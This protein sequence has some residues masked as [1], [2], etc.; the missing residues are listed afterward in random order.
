MKNEKNIIKTQYTV[1]FFF[2]EC[3]MIKYITVTKMNYIFT[4]IYFIIQ[5][6]LISIK[7]IYLLHFFPGNINT[8]LFTMS[9]NRNIRIG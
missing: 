2:Y 9:L 5:C 8:N 4:L 7:K 3:C 1:I 6:A